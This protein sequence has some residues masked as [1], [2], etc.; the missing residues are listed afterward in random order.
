MDAP[1]SAEVTAL[2]RAWSGGDRAALDRLTPV[3]Y[4]ELRPMARPYMRNERAADTLQT[5]ALVNEVGAGAQGLRKFL[6]NASANPEP[7]GCR[8]SDG[9]I[10]SNN[11]DKQEINIKP[12][13][14]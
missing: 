7:S 13:H 6:C 5:T 3:V 2:L 8:G 4:E 1:E 12:T 10:A 11:Q 14:A 9:V